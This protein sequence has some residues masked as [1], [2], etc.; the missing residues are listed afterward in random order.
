MN[1]SLHNRR[2]KRVDHHLAHGLNN[3][4][5]ALGDSGRAFEAGAAFREALS[6][7]YLSGSAL[8]RPERS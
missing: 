5:G 7:C 1:N 2:T 8:K 4:G 6:L 3:L